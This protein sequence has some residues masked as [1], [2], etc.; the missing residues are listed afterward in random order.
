MSKELALLI[1]KLGISEEKVIKNCS[2]AGSLYHDFDV[3]PE[4]FL[5]G[6]EEDFE[7]GGNASLLN[8]IT[9]AK[10]AIHG[11]IDQ[12][13]LSFG[14]KSTRWRLSQKIEML[15]KL[16][17]IA[18]RILKRVTD[19]RNLL[20]HEYS[21]PTIEQVEDSLD[22]AS[23][24]I[25][26]TK[27]FLESFWDDFYLGN[28]DEQVDGFHFKHELSFSFDYREKGFW[29]VGRTNVSP[30]RETETGIVIG[31]VFIKPNEDIFPAIVRLV[32]AGDNDVKIQRA[33]DQ[34]FAN[35]NTHK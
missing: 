28:E 3:N 25:G 15:N 5:E 18:P 33:L 7:L 4:D 29:I 32:V 16:G 20:E 2:G 31:Q 10:R 24:F 35:L 17:F 12:A 30:E 13:L 9:N 1:E 22:L 23:L 26:A 8:A 34:F 14:F 19:A 6:A 27:R 21:A 11:Q